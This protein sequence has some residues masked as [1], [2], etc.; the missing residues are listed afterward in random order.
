MLRLPGG[1]TLG[2]DDR[3]R[4]QL[5][6][7]PRRFAIGPLLPDVTE[8]VRALAGAGLT[9]AELVGRADGDEAVA[10]QLQHVVQRLDAR[11]WIEHSLR[12]DGVVLASLRPVGAPLSPAPPAPDPSAPVVLS[13]FAFVHRDG[14]EMVVESPR[15]TTVVVLHDPRA[16]ALIAR[17]ATPVRAA[18]LHAN[19]PA[20]GAV[21]GLLSD[22]GLLVSAGGAGY[23]EEWDQ[24]LAQW[25]LPDLVFHAASRYGRRAGGYGGTYPLQGRFEPLPE[26]KP[27]MGRP[28]A[29]DRP[30]LAEL[31]AGDPPF[32][33][34]LERRRSIREHDDRAPVTVGRLGDFLYRAA[35]ARPS[36]T[37]PYPTGGGLYELELYPVVN[38]CQGLEP[39]LYHYDP[40]DHRL[41]L[42]TDA[43]PEVQALLD[44]ARGRSLMARTPQVLIVVA[45]RFG[46]VMFKYEAIAYAAILKNV[47][48]LYQTM[49]CVATAMGLAPCALGGGSS[50]AFCAASGLDYLVE[51]T[52]GEFLLGSAVNVASVRS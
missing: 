21:L 14:A 9:E 7:G 10:A 52:V 3:G 2:E 47:G 28:I 45:A 43:G 19:D 38:L 36:G 16:A 42:V 35:G 51:T 33:A 48:A 18:D 6:R 20:A 17:L 13:R 41:G 4:L 11:G 25:S 44:D 30:D 37:R 50:D 49:Y 40:V 34:V 31:G 26:R 46:R 8:A 27:L 24:A 32:S 22:A 1:T 39:G 29:L 15:S 23:D 5:G 12:W